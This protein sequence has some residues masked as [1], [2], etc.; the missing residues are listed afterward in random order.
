MHVGSSIAA[1][2]HSKREAGIDWFD[3]RGGR[4]CT[5]AVRQSGVQST[6]L[7]ATDSGLA[8]QTNDQSLWWFANEEKPVWD[9]RAKPYIYHVY[10]SPKTDIFV[11]TDGRG[12][13]LIAVDPATGQGTF[14]LKPPRGGAGELRKVPGH[15]VLVAKFWTSRRDPIAGRLFCLV[16]RDRSHNLGVDCR[17]L[18]GTWEHG[19]VCQAG[20][21]GER[22]AIVD[23]RPPGREI[24]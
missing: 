24:A 21:N 2:W 20:R 16:M 22:L 7:H 23:V 11:G 19:A 13:R 10:C 1:S 6:R 14:E 8:L 9:L 15:N 3:E 18:I 17:N 12:G 4:I 5:G